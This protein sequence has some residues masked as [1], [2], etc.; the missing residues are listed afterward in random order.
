MLLHLFII[1]LP[2]TS[3]RKASAAEDLNKEYEEIRNIRLQH[4]SIN[5]LESFAAIEG[6][7]GRQK[8]L[9]DSICPKIAFLAGNHKRWETNQLR[10]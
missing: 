3:S 5:P 7:M 2:I 4:I 1:R 9:V 6:R 10:I 8:I